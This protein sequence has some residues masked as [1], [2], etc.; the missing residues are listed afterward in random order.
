MINKNH[1]RCGIHRHTW[2]GSGCSGKGFSV[3]EVLVVLAIFSIL[4]V[5]AT[6]SLF[7]SLRGARKS[8]TISRVKENLD[9][10]VSIMERQLRNSSS[11]VSCS[12]SPP[13]VDYRD[14]LGMASYFSCDLTGGF[15]ASSSA[16]I[17]LTSNNVIV[18]NCAFTCT[19]A[20]GSTNPYI[21]ISITGRDAN[22]VGIEGADITSSIRIY[23]RTYA[24]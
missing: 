22:S 20:S 24:F 9:Y 14:L 12:N 18:T 1:T 3:I 6:Q 13:R 10:S 8:D 15:V 23:L 16:S 7:L 19:G 21:D 4:G 17:R 2:C 11:V 5:L